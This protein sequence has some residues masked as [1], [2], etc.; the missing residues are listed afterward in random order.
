MPYVTLVGQAKGW[1]LYSG[2]GSDGKVLI[3]SRDEV[4][5]SDFDAAEEAVLWLCGRATMDER[6]T[7]QQWSLVDLSSKRID[8]AGGRVGALACSPDGRRVVVLELPT[9]SMRQPLLQLWQEGS[10]NPIE[11]ASAIEISSKLAWLDGERIVFESAARRLTILNL[12]TGEVEEGP[13]GCCPT[14]A[15]SLRQWYAITSGKVKRFGFQVPLDQDP[16]VVTGFDFGLATTARLSSDGEVCT[17]TEPKFLYRSKGFIQ[18]R[19]ERR[20]RFPEIDI[21]IGAVLGPFGI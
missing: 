20:K 11:A 21:G 4:R 2:V 13:P 15:R 3:E 19:G 7:I 10:W 5:L 9:G 12:G 6:I 17:W 18:K 1:A 8:W 14:A 16:N